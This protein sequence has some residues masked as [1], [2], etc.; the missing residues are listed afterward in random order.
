MDN[1][2]IKP[3]K[4]NKFPLLLAPIGA[5][6]AIVALVAIL[7][8]TIMRG[9]TPINT[10]SSANNHSNNRYNKVA[11][12]YD[13]YQPKCNSFDEVAYYSYLA[14]NQ[15][16]DVN[17]KNNKKDYVLRSKNIKAEA[18][19]GT[20][21]ELRERFID[22][23]G[24]EHRPIPLDYP[25]TFSDFL[26]FEFDA[27]D[28][29]FLDERVGNGHIYGLL[30]QNSYLEQD[31]LVLRNGENYYTCL[32]SGGAPVRNGKPGYIQ[33]SSYKT[34]EEF[35]Y[36]TDQTNRRYVTLYF[37]GTTEGIREF[38]TLNSINVDGVDYSINPQTVFYDT[39]SVVLTIGE[40]RQ[41]F[42]LDAYLE[43]SNNYG[44]ADQLV[45]DATVPETANF[46]LEEFDNSFRVTGNE[47][48]YGENKILD[49][50]DIEKIYAA[51]INKDAHR[52]LVFETIEEGN[53]TFVI[54]DVKHNR[55]LYKQDATQIKFDYDFHLDMIDNRL[56]VKW[57]EPGMIDDSYMLD[58]G[59]FAY[60]GQ[61]LGISWNNI[62]G[63][64]PMSITGFY[65]ADGITPVTYYSYHY[66]ISSNTPYIIEVKVS[67]NYIHPYAFVGEQHPIRYK[68]FVGNYEYTNDT[69]DWEQLSFSDDGLYRI[70][71]CFSQSGYVYASV[72]FYRSQ[73]DLSVAIDYASE[74]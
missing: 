21:V 59:R 64:E 13:G 4:A 1:I 51:E 26:Y 17:N 16:S 53:R 39:S 63:V 40:I 73:F 43:L 50:G 30:I 11:R 65:E 46:S 14:Y 70:R 3:K 35:D 2:Q 57:L 18:G 36:V 20:L 12:Y 74:D 47:V 72:Y 38:E 61:E 6:C 22:N 45:Y 24:R 5:A 34:I 7:I 60:S 44:G 52:D 56:V 54:Y 23:Y 42:G 37:G 29:I 55:I 19:P 25:I 49:I 67:T 71:V 28:N 69:I 58:Y 32:V 31:M 10:S 15:E 8:P 68:R 66:R 62:L 48:F 9:G 41:H 27:E 33:F